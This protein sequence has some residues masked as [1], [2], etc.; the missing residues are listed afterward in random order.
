VVL[1][2]CGDVFET[3]QAS[4]KENAI[5][6][7]FQNSR[8][9]ADGLAYLVVHGFPDHRRFR[10]F[11]FNQSVDGVGVGRA[12]VAYKAPGT[13]THPDDVFGGVGFQILGE[14]DAGDAA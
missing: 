8:H 3:H 11:A 7:P 1:N 10:V 14:F 9:R 5:D 12:E 6:M 13:R 4:G 2:G